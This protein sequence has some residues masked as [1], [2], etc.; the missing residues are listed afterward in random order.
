MDIVA[1]CGIHNTGCE[2]AQHDGIHTFHIGKGAKVRYVERHYGEGP[3]TGK[4]VLNP[5]TEVYLEE[6][7]SLTMEMTQIRGV[8][9]TVRDTLVIV[10]PGRGVYHERKAAHRR[11]ADRGEQR[12]DRF[13]RRRRHRTGDLPLGGPRGIRCRCSAPA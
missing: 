13:E 10:G 7:A 1:G 4:R 12:G 9:S 2:T 5:K 11:G 3:G 6:G 8:D